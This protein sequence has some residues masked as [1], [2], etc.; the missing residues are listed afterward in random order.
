MPAN[1][2]VRKK[3]K[4][5]RKNGKIQWVLVFIL[6][7]PVFWYF[8]NNISP[9]NDRFKSLP[10]GFKAYGID[11]SHHQGKINWSEVFNDPE[12]KVQFVYCKATE[13][14]NFTD[15][16][17]SYNKVSLDQHN[18]PNGAYHFFQPDNDPIT[19]ALHFLKNIKLKQHDLPP[20]LD[21]ESE[22]KT[23]ALLISNMNKWLLFI[24]KK[25]G[26][27]PVIYTSYHFYKTKFLN[28]I[29]GY[30]FWIANYADH[31]ERMKDNAIIHWQF[32]ERGQI[33]GISSK[34]D[35]N[36]SKIEFELEN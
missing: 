4:S 33:P 25:T 12:C 7:I 34:V 29:S 20:V 21:V 5:R 6:A 13:G 27:R 9:R 30:K 17:Y 24:E 35:L 19:Q 1:K 36:Y 28:R 10:V 16:L 14:T 2:K 26:R 18:I 15:N 11:I 3:R 8:F 22:G 32:S 23:D 31:P